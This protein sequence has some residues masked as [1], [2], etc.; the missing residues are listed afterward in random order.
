[1]DNDGSTDSLNRPANNGVWFVYGSLKPSELGFRQIRHLIDGHEP[2]K[3]TGYQIVIRDGLPG[4]RKSNRGV[5]DGYL[6]YA[7]YKKE[8]ELRTAIE[9]FETKEKYKFDNI[10]VSNGSEI[11]VQ[12]MATLFKK[13]RESD[14][15]V[16]SSTWRISDDVYFRYGLP[17]LFRMAHKSEKYIGPSDRFDFW[18]EYLPIAGVFLNLWTVLERYIQFAQPA[19]E[20]N[21]EN[22]VPIALPKHLVAI[23]NSEAGKNAYHKVINKNTQ[24][25]LSALGGERAPNIDRYLSQWYCARNNSAHRGKSSFQDHAKVR[26]AA[27][28]LSEFLVALLSQ[29]VKGLEHLEERLDTLST[30]ES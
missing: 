20:S 17:T 12:A 24:K 14:D 28:G 13:V 18:E 22:K 6:L 8:T 23:E 5:V 19:L 10:P 3:V 27:L 26:E 30:S 9:V 25:C 2:A 16:E 7:K 4:L 21:E 1:M 15:L 29:E 11:C